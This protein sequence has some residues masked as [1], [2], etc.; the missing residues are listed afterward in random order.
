MKSL[1][2]ILRIVLVSLCLGAFS[3][4]SFGPVVLEKDIN[5]QVTQDFKKISAPIYFSKKFA[6][7]PRKSSAFMDNKQVFS[8]WLDE[9]DGRVALEKSLSSVVNN[10][11]E[12]PNVASCADAKYCVGLNN[13]YEIHVSNKISDKITIQKFSYNAVIDVKD[14]AGKSI[15]VREVIGEST[16]AEFDDPVD[17]KYLI[18]L[19][20]TRMCQKVS[21]AL[22]GINWN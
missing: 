3:A 6:T 10:I 14:N 20:I 16:S 18:E 7:K 11:F 8:F 22:L 19:A 9:M 17:D 15:L 21:N 1:C 13:I 4:C 5:V 2:K 12:K